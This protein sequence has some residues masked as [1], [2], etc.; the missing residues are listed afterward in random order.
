MI[1]D[2]LIPIQTAIDALF[3]KV[4]PGGEEEFNKENPSEQ[5]EIPVIEVSVWGN[6]AHKMVGSVI[7]NA[8]RRSEAELASNSGNSVGGRDT[9]SASPSNYS[10]VSQTTYTKGI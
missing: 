3:Y 2:N 1:I 6:E 4:R 9:P 8:R 5:N 10:V 7:R